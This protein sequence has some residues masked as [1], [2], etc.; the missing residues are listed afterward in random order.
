MGALDDMDMEAAT[1]ARIVVRGGDAEARVRVVD[2][3]IR[4]TKEMTGPIT[5]VRV[6]GGCGIV[7]A[8]AVRLPNAR[9]QDHVV[10]VDDVRLLDDVTDIEL[11]AWL[12]HGE[13]ARASIIVTDGGPSAFER[14]VPCAPRLR[15]EVASTQWQVVDAGGAGERFE[16]RRLWQLVRTSIV[17]A[18]PGTEPGTWS[19]FVERSECLGFDQLQTARVAALASVIDGQPDRAF[20]QLHRALARS[21]CTTT[22]AQ[23]LHDHAL[24]AAAA[25][26]AGDG[27]GAV[28]ADRARMGIAARM[29][30]PIVHDLA[31]AILVDA[32]ASGDAQLQAQAHVCR[33]SSRSLGPVVEDEWHID[34][35][36]GTGWIAC[37][38]GV[39][40]RRSGNAERAVRRGLEAVRDAREMDDVDLEQLASREL[41]RSLHEAGRVDEAIFTM[42]A[43]VTRADRS[44]VLGEGDV[45]LADA[46]SMYSDVL[47][48]RE[49]L[50]SAR[51]LIARSVGRGV[52][53]GDTEAFARASAAWALAALGH[54]D[55]ARAEVEAAIRLFG[56]HSSVT[57]RAGVLSAH[58]RVLADCGDH[59]SAA[60]ALARHR[61]VMVH[62]EFGAA[63]VELLDLRVAE[64]A[65]GT[66]LGELVQ[67]ACA[68][69]EGP[70]P[71]PAM[72]KLNFAVW[73][74]RTAAMHGH[75]TGL[76]CAARLA[77]DLRDNAS[78]VSRLVV[79]QIDA[80]VAAWAD[81]S[82]CAELDDVIDRWDELGRPIDAARARMV[83]ARILLRHGDRDAAATRC[84]IAHRAF[85]A[86]GA[87]FDARVS[88]RLA[89]SIAGR[90]TALEP[91][92]TRA[93]LRL[94]GL[95]A[96]PSEHID[97]LALRRI[98]RPGEDVFVNGDA[99]NDVFVVFAG[100]VQV[101]RG[102]DD[103]KVLTID[104][105]GPGGMFGEAA[106]LGT[107]ARIGGTR[108]VGAATIGRIT[109]SSMRAAIE[110]YPAIGAALF[111]VAARRA[112][113]GA[114]VAEAVAYWPVLRRL[115]ATIL[116]LEPTFG[117]PTLDGRTLL[118]V[119]L[120]HDHVASMIGATRQATGLAVREL[121]ADRIIDRDRRRFV[122]LDHD[123]LVRRADLR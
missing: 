102:V 51:V 57:F 8:P 66:D 1:G 72:L 16:L 20:H 116:E 81:P 47:R 6:G 93:S 49:S 63:D 111:A 56:V 76:A 55:A 37:L 100:A 41:A 96:E 35:V 82:A 19:E 21:T 107:G 97:A 4:S 10:I 118:N 115:A 7:V 40:A 14:L 122:I 70:T 123:E 45:V 68:I 53:G 39:H 29:R 65:P 114:R 103:G 38:D 61:D 90:R 43:V 34:T 23:A 11:V 83:C 27:A 58:V 113:R 105:V 2:G 67:R 99:A 64:L 3:L 22:A 91:D 30:H 84:D 33:L 13:A 95:P 74:T 117:H 79:R 52:E 119:A 120:T 78:P 92:G 15:G 60:A 104:L 85:A 44:G 32:V 109:R 101:M 94:L 50:D 26:L 112:E 42:R 62:R 71:R 59:L 31:S 86:A 12:T 89:R 46:C 18:D 54:L 48:T 88:Y 80:T 98:C 5:Q 87:V 17:G 110:T 25:R 121:R 75:E 77:S 9:R 69:V 28:A 73:L 24:L 108:A 36:D 106:I